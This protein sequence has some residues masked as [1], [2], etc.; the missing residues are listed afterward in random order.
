MR[1]CQFLRNMACWPSK[2]EGRAAD[3]GQTVEQRGSSRVSGFLGQQTQSLHEKEAN[4]IRKIRHGENRDRAIS[5]QNW[6]DYSGQAGKLPQRNN[7]NFHRSLQNQPVGVESKPA[8]LR[9][10]FQSK[11]WMQARVFPVSSSLLLPFQAG[12]RTFMNPAQVSPG[13]PRLNAPPRSL[14][15]WPL[16]RTLCNSGD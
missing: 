8:T 7:I 12:S 13:P 14:S 3:R 4:P 15:M 6:S 2:A 1:C 5:P 16:E 10:F 11:F 9:C